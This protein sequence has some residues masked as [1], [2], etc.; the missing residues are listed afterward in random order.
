[1]STFANHLGLDLHSLRSLYLDRTLLGGMTTDSR[2]DDGG[3]QLYARACVQQG[4]IK[5]FIYQGK[6]QPVLAPKKNELDLWTVV[7]EDANGE[8]SFRL[9]MILAAQPVKENGPSPVAEAVAQ[10]NQEFIP[11][12][13]TMP[14]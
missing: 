8:T 5:R 12:D 10:A 2:A 9:D 11:A 13:P 6:E 7:L 1:M 14:V 3:R 4:L